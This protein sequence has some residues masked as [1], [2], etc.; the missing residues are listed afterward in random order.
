MEDLLQK[1]KT[2]LSPGS[3]VVI[4]YGGHAMENEELKQFFCEDIAGLSKVHTRVNYSQFLFKLILLFTD[5]YISSD[6]PW[7][8]TANSE[9]A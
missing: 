6:C 3:L 2:N 1:V 4:K 5:W 9:N 8:W 7:W